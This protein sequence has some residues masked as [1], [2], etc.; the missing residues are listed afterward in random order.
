MFRVNPYNASRYIRPEPAKP[1]GL[2]Y[3]NA[4]EAVRGRCVGGVWESSR[5]CVLK[6]PMRALELVRECVDPCKQ[7]RA[8]CMSQG[9]HI[10]GT[11]SP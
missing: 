10:A 9:K 11:C 5:N 7:M 6:P 8:L 4:H 2:L 1:R 3:G